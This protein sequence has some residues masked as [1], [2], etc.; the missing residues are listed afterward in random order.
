MDRFL[1]GYM[2][3]E[4]KKKVSDSADLLEKRKAYESKREWSFQTSWKT[5]Y[6]W[7]AYNEEKK[8]MTCSVCVTY[9]TNGSFVSGCSNLRLEAIKKHCTSTGHFDNCKKDDA[10]KHKLLQESQAGRSLL[11]MNK[12]AHNKLCHLFRNAHYVAKLGRPYSDYVPLCKLDAAKSYDVGKTYLTN[13]ACQ[14][15]VSAIAED[16]RLK[17]DEA[18]FNNARFISLISD[19]STDSSSQE[20]EI[21]YARCAFQGKVSN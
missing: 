14:Q 2:P 11:Q 6:A 3:P 10:K 16:C 7:L 4:K 20:A 1:V 9:E 17:Q 5:D 21:L 15:F 19:G 13:K 12:A 8:T 18:C